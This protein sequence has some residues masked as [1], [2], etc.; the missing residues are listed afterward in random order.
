M[1]IYR[2]AWPSEDPVAQTKAYLYFY[3]C[4]KYMLPYIYRT[5]G[6]QIAA[7]THKKASQY[8]WWNNSLRSNYEYMIFP[9]RMLCL[10]C[11]ARLMEKK[12]RP[13]SM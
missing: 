1:K 2:N 8:L 7:R 10:L 9:R 12:A 4:P 5:S 11:F 13:C 3:T 6:V